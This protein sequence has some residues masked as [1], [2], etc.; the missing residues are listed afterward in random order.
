MMRRND[1]HVRGRFKISF[2]STFSSAV[3]EAF[4]PVVFASSLERNKEIFS[5]GIPDR[6]FKGLRV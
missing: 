4:N 3:E 2:R 1:S 6:G 5:G